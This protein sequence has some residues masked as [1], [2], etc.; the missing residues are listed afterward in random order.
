[1]KASELIE[2]FKAHPY[3]QNLISGGE[4]VEY[5]AHLIPVTGMKIVPKLAADGVLVTGDAAGL[6]L[7]TGL[8]L[9]GANFAMASGPGRGRDSHQGQGEGRFLSGDPGAATNSSSTRALSSGS[10]RPTGRRP[11][12]LHNERIYTTYPELAC[13]LALNVFENDGTLREGTFRTL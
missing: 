3:I 6:V 12:F 1:M 10:S 9:E 2:D 8:I 13:S 7:G 11:S 5:S 4:T